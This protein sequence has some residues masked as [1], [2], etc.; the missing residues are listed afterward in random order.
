MGLGIDYDIV[1]RLH[2]TFIHG[3]SGS[4]RFYLGD[5]VGLERRILFR[6]VLADSLRYLLKCIAIRS[7]LLGLNLQDQADEIIRTIDSVDQGQANLWQKNWASIVLEVEPP[8]DVV[9]FIDGN[10]PGTGH[11]QR[12]KEMVSC[13]S[14]EACCEYL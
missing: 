11:P 3:T 7:D 2:S 13:M 10:Q 1:F 8:D 9:V 12:R 4:L 14:W 6:I 5:E